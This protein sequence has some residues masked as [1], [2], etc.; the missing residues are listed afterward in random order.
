MEGKMKLF[1]KPMFAV[2]VLTAS[3]SGAAAG[4]SFSAAAPI[5]QEQGQS[6]TG[7]KAANHEVFGTIRSIKGLRLTVET[8]T[9]KLVQLDATPATQGHRVV[10]L[11]VTNAIDAVGTVDKSGVFHAETIQHAKP[12]PAIWPPDR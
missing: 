6:K 12:S 3:I 11:A 4:A 2:F 9:G 10:P 5:P 8:R 7:E 1:R